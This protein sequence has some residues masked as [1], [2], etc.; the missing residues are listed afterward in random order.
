MERKVITLKPSDTVIDLTEEIAKRAD[1]IYAG[2]VD[3]HIDNM[4]KVTGDGKKLAL[5]PRC[6]DPLLSDESGSKLNYCADN[7][8]EEWKNSTDIKGTQLVFCDLSTPKKPYSEYVY[9]TDFDAY[10]DLKHK[11]VERGIPENEICTAGDATTQ[12]QCACL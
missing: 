4:L 10:N 3:P 6:I 1:A 8:Y 11:L 12:K 2:G 5:D 7:V 9:G